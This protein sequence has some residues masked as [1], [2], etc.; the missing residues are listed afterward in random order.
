MKKSI[1][2]I[3]TLGAFLLG[4]QSCF[5]AF[6]DAFC[7]SG[8][9][10]IIKEEISLEDFQNI[11]SLTVVD[12]EIEQG[13]SQT[14]IIEGHENMIDELY[15]SVINEELRIDL[16]DDCY[17]DFRL[18]VYVTIPVLKKLKIESTGDVELGSFKNLDNLSIEISS[19]GDVIGDGVLEITEKLDIEIS[20]TGD[21]K[22]DVYTQDI[23][24]DLSSTGN[25]ALKGSCNTQDIYM[26]GTADYFAYNLESEICYIENDGIGDA[27]V[28]VSDELDVRIS[29]V[30][31]VYYIGEPTVKEYNSG[32]GNLINAN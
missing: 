7:Q 5:F 14:V 2:L 30:G 11:T 25:L 9:G 4:T 27:K 28:Y 21:I 31:D 18:K 13:D 17:N 22:L 32:P 3:A 20:S 12:I 23:N 15:L 19:T 1:L 16:K 6:N 8:S 10:N 24:I 29:S 26:D